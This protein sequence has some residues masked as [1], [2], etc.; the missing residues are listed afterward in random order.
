V[1]AV[2]DATVQCRAVIR[3]C[4]CSGIAFLSG[5]QSA[6][7]GLLAL[8]ERYELE[9]RSRFSVSCS[10]TAL[11][12][13]VFLARAI[14]QPALELWQERRLMYRQHNRFYCIEPGAMEQRVRR[15]QAAMKGRKY[16]Y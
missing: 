11:G 15:I 3:S 12:I 6:E 5:G 8:L 4:R 16:E 2:A 14:Q 10:A 1:E 9:I 7:P 13:D